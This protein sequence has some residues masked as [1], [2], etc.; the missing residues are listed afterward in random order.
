M[1]KIAKDWDWEIGATTSDWSWNIKD[2]WQYRHLLFSLVKRNLILNYQQTIL[3]P[4]WTLLQP[5]LTLIIYVLVFGK[6]VG[7]STGSLPPVLFYFSGIVLWNFFSDSFLENSNTFR[8]NIYLFSKVYFPRI[9]LPVSVTTTH[10][11]RLLIQL[12]FLFL[13]ILFYSIVKD[14]HIPF[15]WQLLL[16]PFSVFMIGSLGLGLGLACSVLTAKYRDLSNL[17][18]IGIRLLMF[19]TPVIYP[20]ASIKSQ[21]QWIVLLNPLTPFFELFRLSL[22]GEGTITLGQLVASTLF[23]ITVTIISLLIFNKQGNKLIDVV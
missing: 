8:D 16:F 23:I 2:V 1:P 11:F 18:V 21:L 3:G 4:F 22:L 15:S 20:L 5:L 6:I 7:V 14:F 10:F 19:V 17:V 13:L 12:L 9:I